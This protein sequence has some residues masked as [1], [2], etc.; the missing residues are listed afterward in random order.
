MLNASALRVEWD[1]ED[2]KQIEE[3]KTIYRKAK[4][5][6]RIITDI[7]DNVI[8][9]FHPKLEAIKIKEIELKETQF[10]IRFFDETG[11]RR[12]IW[13]SSDPFQI[14]DAADKFKEYIDKGWRGF[15]T[16][17]KGNRK[18]RVYAFDAQKEEVL[19]EEITDEQILEK[20]NEKLTKETDKP[21]LMKTEKLQNF[22][23]CFNKISAL[24]KTIAG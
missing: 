2:K 22:V 11:D 12:I 23:K 13:D 7:H 20:F 18:R 1:Q 6:G 19:F 8:Q 21:K 16:D 24:P 14:K 17:A 15:A 5:E 4:G 10:S 3:A 9:F